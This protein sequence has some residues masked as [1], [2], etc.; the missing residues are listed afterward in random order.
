ML[1]KITIT[2]ALVAV[3]LIS[4]A[5]C[6]YPH[7]ID[8]TVLNRY[9][10]SMADKSPQARSAESGL[11][12]LQ[13]EDTGAPQLELVKDDQTGMS[14]L[15]LSLDEAILRA[16]FN[17]LDI[18]VVSFDPAIS[19]EETVKAAAEFDYILFGGGSMEKEDSP[20]VVHSKTWAYDFGVSQ[21]SVTGAEWAL[22]WAMNYTWDVAPFTPSLLGTPIQ[23]RYTPALTFQITQP[24]L[25]DL[26]PE[27]NLATLR[28]AEVSHRIS[29]T[30]FRALVEEV[31]TGVVNTYWDLVRARKDMLILEELLEKTV[32]TLE[33]VQAR[34]EL[35]ATA[36][37]IKQAEA[38]VE[39]R[40]ATLIIAKNVILD[41]QDSLSRQ[42]ADEQLN[43]LTDFEI[44]PTTPLNTVRVQLDVEDQ[45]ETAL[46]YNPDLEQTRLL[47]EQARINVKV[48][49]N[50]VLPRLDLSAG[51]SF[52]GL[53][54]SIDDSRESL[55]DGDFA[56]YNISIRAE[57]PI[58]N[59]EREADLRQKRLELL[60]SLTSVQNTADK[61]AQ[62]VR[63]RIRQVGAAYDEM[64]A[65]T[66]AVAAFRAQLQ[67]LEDT[68]RIRGRL[69]PEFLQV[70]LDTQARLALAEQNELR[71]ATEYNTALADLARTTGTVLLQNKVEIALPVATGDEDWPVATKA[72]TQ[73][74]N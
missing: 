14:Q 26:G 40:R 45:L 65:Q 8:Q 34:A 21:K 12:Y 36:V 74:A 58:G 50:Q 41:V 53:S 59:R 25:R 29:Q 18:R 5:G 69:T 56:S 55:T 60:K 54:G 62:V 13:P 27:F 31:V 48:A 43:S 28:I 49:K 19:Y 16:I 32:Q 24:L 4:I 1:N 63:E 61:V 22:S 20:A 30:E 3:L 37:Q 57:Y 68:E 64:N 46:R 38:A 15:Y 10:K 6:V 72:H 35:D 11:G 66:A 23:N 47:V 44:V 73:P 51:G 33:R 67:A 9:Q 70:K 39:T 52:E 2:N 7:R 17:N 71:S 42:L